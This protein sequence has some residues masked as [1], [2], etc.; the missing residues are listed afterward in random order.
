MRRRRTL[1]PEEILDAIIQQEIEAREKLLS[2]AKQTLLMTQL[3]Q[4]IIGGI[5]GAAS[6]LYL[7]TH[8]ATGKRA[9]LI[10]AL[11][12]L[13][14][15]LGGATLAAASARIQTEPARQRAREVAEEIRFLRSLRQSPLRLTKLGLRILPAMPKREMVLSLLGRPY[16]IRR[17]LR[18]F[19][20]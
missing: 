4:P 12:T 8:L 14:G 3:M 16:L 11:S 1:T 2:H 7:A 5:T 15:G 17:S 18:G 19:Y 13:L 9:P 10:R 6:A 20:V